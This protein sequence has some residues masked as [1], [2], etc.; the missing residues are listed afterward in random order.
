MVLNQVSQRQQRELRK[1]AVSDPSRERPCL[2]DQSGRDG[3]I[4]LG[5]APDASQ[6][7]GSGFAFDPHLSAPDR[8]HERVRDVSGNMHRDGHELTEVW[9]Q[10]RALDQVRCIDG[11]FL[12]QGT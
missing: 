1:D 9:Q 7:Q 6:E 2:R 8:F 11:A 10:R 4:G 3:L 12:G 5:G